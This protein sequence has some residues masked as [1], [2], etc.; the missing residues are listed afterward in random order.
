LFADVASGLVYIQRST[1]CEPRR[2]EGRRLISLH[3]F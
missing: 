2:E 3:T 1:C